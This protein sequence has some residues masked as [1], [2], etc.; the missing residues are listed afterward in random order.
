MK[1]EL[2]AVLDPSTALVPEDGQWCIFSLGH[3]RIY[4]VS[5]PT[6]LPAALAALRSSMSGDPFVALDLE[7][8]PDV[9]GAPTRVALLQ[10]ASAT[11]S[12]L[13]RT[14]RLP[15]CQTLQD[16]LW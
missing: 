8:R 5:A 1:Q 6:Q 15:F 12:V 2:A 3:C 7:W 11:V 14:C 10:L 9:K 4:V 16:F 13:V